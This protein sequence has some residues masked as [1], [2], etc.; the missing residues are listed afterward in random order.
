MYTKASC[1]GLNAHEF[2]PMSGTVS[3]FQQKNTGE[4]K[5]R[6]HSPQ[7]GGRELESKLQASK[8][9]ETKEGSL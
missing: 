6:K 4:Q 1:Q 8:P 5:Q 9:V 2:M 7:G 3:L